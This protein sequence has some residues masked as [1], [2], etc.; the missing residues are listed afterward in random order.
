MTNE[1]SCLAVIAAAGRDAPFEKGGLNRPATARPARP[2]GKSCRDEHFKLQ[3]QSGCRILSQKLNKNTPGAGGPA[4]GD[5]L[6]P[7]ACAG[8]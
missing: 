2:H 4:W 7:Q 3:I 5:V 8:R 1:K 6:L